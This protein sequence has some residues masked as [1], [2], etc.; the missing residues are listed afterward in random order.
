MPPLVSPILPCSP[1]GGI[2]YRP[3]LSSDFALSLPGWLLSL[4]AVSARQGELW[5]TTPYDQVVETHADLCFCM[6]Q[7]MIDKAWHIFKS[8]FIKEMF[9]SVF[10]C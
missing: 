2:C 6:C 8:M 9:L 3:T 10:W 4:T 1:I 7:S 5:K